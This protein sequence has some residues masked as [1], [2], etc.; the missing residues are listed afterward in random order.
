MISSRVAPQIICLSSGLNEVEAALNAELG[1]TKTLDTRVQGLESEIRETTRKL[2]ESTARESTLADKTKDQE[3]ELQLVQG[4]VQNLRSEANRYR[5]R[6]REL[7]D[8]IQNDDRAERL[9]ESLKNTQDK[10]DNLEFK[11]G[12][13]QQ[14][15][16]QD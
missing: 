16:C 6:V 14:V 13:L 3:R 8:Q 9:E 5:T 12:K 2:T 11:L 4:E 1:K 10:A 7:E 15:G